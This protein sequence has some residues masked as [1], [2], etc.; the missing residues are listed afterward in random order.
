MED[1]SVEG[2]GERVGLVTYRR[3]QHG[4]VECGVAFVTLHEGVELVLHFMLAFLGSWLCGTI[5]SS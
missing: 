1:W 3:D 5:S 2:E 4:A